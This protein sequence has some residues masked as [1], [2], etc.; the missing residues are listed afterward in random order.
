MNL[1]RNFSLFIISNK[2]AFSHEKHVFL[3]NNV[4]YNVL[5]V[6]IFRLHFILHMTSCYQVKK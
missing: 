6:V 4:G 3:G 5:K 1:S 2:N